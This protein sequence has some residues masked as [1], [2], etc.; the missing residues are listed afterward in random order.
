MCLKSLQLENHSNILNCLAAVTEDEE[1]NRPH[2]N[3]LEITKV[4]FQIVYYPS[5]WIDF[6]PSN[7]FIIFGADSKVWE[8]LEKLKIKYPFK[9]QWFKT[10]MGEFHNWVI[11][12]NEWQN[13][14]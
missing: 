11:C 7:H 6:H 5:T 2:V 10:W 1:I 3:P 12:T 13:G 9:Y 8:H 4:M 14:F